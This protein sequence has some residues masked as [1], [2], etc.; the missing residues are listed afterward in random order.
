MTEPCPL[1]WLT[2]G[3]PLRR[4]TPKPYSAQVTVAGYH[5][6][7]LAQD[8][9]KQLSS[10]LAGKLADLGMVDVQKGGPEHG[11]RF[12]HVHFVLLGVCMMLSLRLCIASLHMHMHQRSG[13]GGGGASGG[14]V[15][16]TT[17]VRIV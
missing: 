7:V 10:F 11:C 5:V 9:L 12:I 4:Q 2:C 16:A 15:A 8:T 17:T 13:G 14:T 6:E 3:C 1:W